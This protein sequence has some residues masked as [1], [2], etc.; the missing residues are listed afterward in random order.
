MKL[1][2]FICI[3]FAAN[4][5]FAQDSAQ[6]AEHKKQM[7]AELEKR[8]SL[9]QTE[10]TCIDG[11]ADHNAVKTCKEAS[12]AAHEKLQAEHRQQRSQNI[13]QQMKKLQE[14][15]DKLQKK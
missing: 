7:S 10:K 1:M 5:S 14:E 3:C 9:L 6:F 12:K 15:K 2:T 4:L 13:D 8:I 11:A